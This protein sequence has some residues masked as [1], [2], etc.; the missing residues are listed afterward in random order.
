M[1]HAHALAKIVLLLTVVSIPHLALLPDSHGDEL[2]PVRYNGP[3][4]GAD[5]AHALAVDA[6]G[7]AYVT[8][9]SVGTGS[10]HDYLTIK[11]SPTGQRLWVSRY[12]GSSNASDNA[13]AVAVD[14]QGNVYVTGS[15][16]E[17][18]SSSD[19]VTIKY[20]PSGEQLWVKRYNNLED[21]SDRAT[22]LAVD[23]QGNVYVTG[24][25]YWTSSGPDY[26]TVK[27]S[28]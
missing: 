1:R 10:Y 17:K 2:W 7:N 28:Q 19:Y 3:G 15:A 6:Q 26:V 25:S 9:E 8:G 21:D 27:Y 13:S 5:D 18:D 16:Q 23:G 11:Y 20:S 4:N 22:A 24:R 14:G 12:G